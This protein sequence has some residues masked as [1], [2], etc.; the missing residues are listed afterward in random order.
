MQL[1]DIETAV[2]VF[3]QASRVLADALSKVFW[4][5]ESCQLAGF[6]ANAMGQLEI[7]LAMSNAELKASVEM[8]RNGQQAIPRDEPEVIAPVAVVEPPEPEQQIFMLKSAKFRHH[9]R[10]RFLPQF[11]DATVPTPLAQRALRCG[12]A[13]TITD[14][15]RKQL[16]GTRSGGI[17]PNAIDVVDLDEIAEPE[18][19]K[20]IGP[21]EVLRSA[22]F[23]VIPTRDRLRISS[24][25]VVHD[26]TSDRHD[27]A[28]SR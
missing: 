15:R 27:P 3:M 6:L 9:G 26:A 16:R 13:T 7:G 2:P 8:I 23:Q 12:C 5:Y 1:T 25:R 14:D 22:N 10:M 20:Y 19:V 18:A 28:P 17:K 11:E 21:D 24:L 4:H